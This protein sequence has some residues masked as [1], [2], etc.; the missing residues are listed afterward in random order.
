ML[1]PAG[2]CEKLLVTPADTCRTCVCVCFQGE[3]GTN[4]R[5]C[6]ALHIAACVNQPKDV[7]GCPAAPEEFS[8]TAFLA[9]FLFAVPIVRACVFPRASAKL[10]DTCRHLPWRVLA[11]KYVREASRLR[12]PKPLICR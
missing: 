7:Q 6:P 11:P 4:C 12:L 1:T 9:S 5:R 8:F 2:T 3:Q 10:P